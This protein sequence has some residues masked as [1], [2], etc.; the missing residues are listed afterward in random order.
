MVVSIKRRQITNFSNKMFGVLLGLAHIALVTG[1]EWRNFIEVSVPEDKHEGYIVYNGLPRP[2]K[3]KKY[4]L[5]YAQG[6]DSLEKVALFEVSASGLVTAVQPL[7]FDKGRPNRF[8]LTIVLRSMKESDGGMVTTLRVS[9]QDIINFPPLFAFNSYNGYIKES[10]PE[11]TVVMGLENCYAE[12]RDSSG[13]K[14]YKII[15]GNERGYF[16]AEKD[17]I[18]G[19]SFL[20]LSNSDSKPNKEVVYFAMFGSGLPFFQVDEGTGL[21]KTAALIDREKQW[22]Y[23]LLIQARTKGN[24]KRYS[25]IYLM[26]NIRGV[27][28]VFPDFVKPV[29]NASVP[30][31]SP[32]GTFVTVIHAVD[33]DNPSVTYENMNLFTEFEMERDTGVIRTKRVLDRVTGDKEFLLYVNAIDGGGKSSEAVVNVK[34]ISAQNSVPKFTR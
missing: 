19:K 17:D 16:T 1:A 26:I 18:G 34:V 14:T 12:D 27:D 9:V 33:K 25:H 13:V 11:N 23:D 6:A 28:D 8:D 4:S 21:V 32:E 30:E 2:A 15:K 22:F 5:V 20:V 31:G 3:G 7:S 29:Y 24:L 10:A